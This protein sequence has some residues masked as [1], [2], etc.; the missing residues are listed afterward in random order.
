MPDPERRTV[1]ASQVAALFNVSPYTTRWMLYQHFAHGI[2]MSPA[3]STRMTW[4][5]RLEPLVLED[6]ARDWKLEIAPNRRYVRHRGG[7]LGATADAAIVAPDRGPGVVEVKCVFDYS[8][9]GHEWELG[10]HV[11]RHHE[12]QLQTQMLVGDGNRSFDWG[13]IVVWICGGEL[14]YFERRPVPDLW[15]NIQKEALRFFVAVEKKEEPDAFG[16]PVEIPWLTSIYRTNPDSVL[17]LSDS[18]DGKTLIQTVTD[19][20]YCKETAR[21]HKST[22][23]NLRARLLGV[24]KENRSVVL[25]DGYGFVVRAS[26]KGKTIDVT[27]PNDGEKF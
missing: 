11:P 3:E 8:I 17:D 13:L 12:I 9:W 19:Y 18:A 27:V 20:A 22:E 14:T 10:K 4:G 23:D 7:L 2:D 1:S 21:A 24:A 16:S 15:D 6:V 5:K 25:P 26:G